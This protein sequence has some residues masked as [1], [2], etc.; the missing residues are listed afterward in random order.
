MDLTQAIDRHAEWKT[1]FRKAM[2]EHQSLDAAAIAKDNCCDLGKWL[3]GEAKARYGQLPSFSACVAKHAA[4]HAEAGKVAHA[5]NAK[6]FDEAESMLGAGTGYAAAST[7]A[8]AAIL[9]LKKEA[10]L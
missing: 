3:H 6:I 1:R 4:F 7:A 2:T 5:I 8:G 9:H 10:A